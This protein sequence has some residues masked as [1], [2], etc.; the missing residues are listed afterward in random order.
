MNFTRCDK[1]KEFFMYIKIVVLSV[2]RCS[3]RERLRVKGMLVLVF[4]C[5]DHVLNTSCIQHT[6]IHNGVFLFYCV[7]F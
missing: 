2:E 4:F 6:H 5:G 3:A 7:V 1:R